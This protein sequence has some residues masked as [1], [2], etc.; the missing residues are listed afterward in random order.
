MK[1]LTV[2]LFFLVFVSPPIF[3][4]ASAEKPLSPESIQRNL[5]GPIDA[6]DIAAASSWATASGITDWLGPLAP[7]A[8]SPFFGVTCLSGLALWGP[9]WISDNAVLGAAG[10]LGNEW[11]F[12]IFL[13]LTLLTSLPRLTKV[14]KPFAQAVDRLETYAVI[15]IL[16]AIK[17]VMSMDSP[18]QESVAALQVPVMQFGVIS[19]TLD[20]LLSIAM[21]VNILVINSVKFFFEFMVWLTP[22]PFLDAVFELCNKSLCALLMGIYAYSPTV[23][24]A[25]NLVLL[26]IAAL[27]LRWI[28]RRVRFYRTMILD[29][30]LAKLWT[31]FGTPRRPEL[32]VFPQDDC[33]PFPAKSRLRLF[34]TGDGISLNQANWWSPEKS[35]LFSAD[36]KPIVRRG[37]VMHTIELKDGQQ[38][39]QLK[40]SRRYSDAELVKLL[41][42]M[43]IEQ[44][45]AE[46]AVE[47]DRSVE[48]A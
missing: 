14:S 4:F 35:H 26:G 6:D 31:G 42:R 45:K 30:I 9:S 13:V 3:Q 5:D 43:G 34:S 15:V 20:T 8:L 10:P 28:S 24:T 25:I 47:T 18:D 23:A 22:V 16:L 48:F 2:F 40:F 27:M 21:I 1:K 44:D 36:C 12:G 11:L 37:W 33:G 41:T 7:V 17:F 32:I 38:V 29:P 39:T 19:L 46:A